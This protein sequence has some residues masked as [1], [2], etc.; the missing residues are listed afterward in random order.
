M[1]KIHYKKILFVQTAFIGDVLLSFP[2]LRHIKSLWP[3][4]EL[5]ILVRKGLGEM[6][7]QAK[8]ADHFI[9]I[10]KNQPASYSIARA[11]I[12]DGHFD[13]IIS[14]H[15]S[16]RTA[17]MLRGLKA[18]KIGF[19]SWWNFLF[20]NKRV[21][22]QKGWPEVYRQMSLIAS[23]DEGLLKRIQNYMLSEQI[24]SGGLPFIEEFDQ[25]KLRELENVA[26]THSK[27]TNTCSQTVLTF[28]SKNSLHSGFV[29]LAPGSVWA[30]KKWG[31]E[32]YIR[33]AELLVAKGYEVVLLGS[34]EER[35][36]CE[37]ICRR[38]PCVVNA[39]G[40]FKLWQSCELLSQAKGIVCNDSGSMHMAS[41]VGLPTVSIFGPTV[42]DFG[43]RPWNNKSIVVENNDLACRPCAKHGGKKCPIG[44]HICMTSISAEHVLNQFEKLTN[45]QIL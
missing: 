7:L 33:L 21:M 25:M 34:P 23:F 11:S 15:R 31:L 45:P 39:A 1:T 40:E 18:Y 27:N 9:E 42:L 13:L 36:L 22:L 17:W 3:D 10:T 32:S 14:P 29:V 35:E 4:A 30:T 5:T 41:L 38:V 6:V 12:V 8:Q 26:R 44:T 20:F 19:S 24:G 2:T 28:L 43:Y 37:S 16:V